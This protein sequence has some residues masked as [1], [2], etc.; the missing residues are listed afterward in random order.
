MQNQAV[1]NT[2]LHAAPSSSCVYV[3]NGWDRDPSLVSLDQI[4]FHGYSSA[5]LCR[6]SIA[7]INKNK[8]T[9]MS[10]HRGAGIRCGG[11]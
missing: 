2:N 10:L 6:A 3:F 5:W 8:H 11:H 1:V 7:F 4:R 9:E